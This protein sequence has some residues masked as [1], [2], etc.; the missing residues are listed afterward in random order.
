MDRLTKKYGC[1][2]ADPP[3]PEIGGGKIKRG[4]DRHY[5]T[6]TVPQ[7]AALPVRQHVLPDSHL[8]LWV[9]NNYLRKAFD[10]VD[11]WGFSYISTITWEKRRAG[12]GQY[13]RGT[14]EHLLFCKRGQP[15]YRVK[16]DGKRAQGLT[17]FETEGAWF[18]AKRGE[19]SEKPP[20]PYEW[21]QLVSPGPYLEM[22]A[23]NPRT[24]WDVWGAEA[25]GADMRLI[26]ILS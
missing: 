4:A 23:R 26:D 5:P 16:P 14:T 11:A 10:V 8:Y 25:E 20:L 15:A 12:L 22:F 1:V 6:M 7:I 18:E 2:V 9:T 24:G 3:W 21:A 19:H 17:G 13:F